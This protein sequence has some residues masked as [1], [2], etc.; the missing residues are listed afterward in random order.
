LRR[1][2]VE[3]RSFNPFFACLAPEFLALI[4]VVQIVLVEEV[5]VDKAGCCDLA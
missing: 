5:D 1:S 2:K 4:Q 3:C